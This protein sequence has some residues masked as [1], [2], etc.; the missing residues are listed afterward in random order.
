MSAFSSTAVLTDRLDSHALAASGA[1]RAALEPSAV[2]RRPLPSPVRAEPFSVSVKIGGGIPSAV[3][4]VKDGPSDP[5]ELTGRA[6][7]AARPRSANHTRSETAN[8]LDPPPP[9][10]PPP[11]PAPPRPSGRRPSP[12]SSRRDSRL[13]TPTLPCRLRGVGEG[14]A[15]GGVPVSALPPRPLSSLPPSL[16][17]RRPSLPRS[18]TRPGCPAPLGG[19]GSPPRTLPPS[20]G[21]AGRLFPRPWDST[22]TRS[23]GAPAWT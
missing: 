17:C 14:K 2:V 7:G 20:L 1:R 6:R 11:P 5:R 22:L 16:S 15:F 19:S 4:A 18:M 13:P 8:P 10:P 9:P 21:V 23:F 12:S 3:T